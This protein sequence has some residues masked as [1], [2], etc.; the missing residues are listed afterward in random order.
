MAAS[1]HVK[2]ERIRSECRVLVLRTS[3]FLALFWAEL[4]SPSP[5]LLRLTSLSHSFQKT[6]KL[7]REAFDRLVHMNPLSVHTFSRYAEFMLQV[8]SPAIA[9]DCDRACCGGG[10]A[11]RRRCRDGDCC[12]AVGGG[13]GCC[14]VA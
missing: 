14:G 2:F 1:T 6:S 9:S 8:C 5:S 11:R 10:G 7:A 13:G 3:R 12:F 4:D